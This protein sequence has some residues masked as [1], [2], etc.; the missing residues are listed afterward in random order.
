MSAAKNET[1]IATS[2]E[3]RGAV[4][5]MGHR[6]RVTGGTGEKK[7]VRFALSPRIIPDA[8]FQLQVECARFPSQEEEE[9]LRSKR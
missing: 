1:K 2:D 4:P 5:K 7:R 6:A 9:Q 3:S 8:W